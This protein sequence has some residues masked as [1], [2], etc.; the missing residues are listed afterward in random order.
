MHAEVARAHA[1]VTRRAGTRPRFARTRARARSARGRRRAQRRRAHGARSRAC[2]SARR[3]RARRRGPARSEPSR[4]RSAR[5]RRRRS[6]P[7]AMLRAGGWACSIKTANA[8]ASHAS[9]CWPRS[10]R[11]AEQTRNAHAHVEGLRHGVSDLDAKLDVARRERETM[12]NGLL[13]LESDLRS[14]ENDERDAVAGGE[15]HRTRSAE[16]EAELGMLVSQFAQNPATDDECHDVEAALRRQE[17]DTR[18]R[19]FAA[20]ARRACAALGQR[21]P[22]RRG[23][24]RRSCRTR[25]VSA[26]ADGRS[27]QSARDA[28]RIDQ[29]DRGAV[30]SAL[31]RDLREGRDRVHR[32]VRQTLPR[33]RRQDVADQSGES[34]GD[35]HRDRRCSRRA[36]S[37]CRSPRSRAANAR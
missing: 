4:G 9:R 15:R 20:S 29:G 14:A 25:N 5:T 16:I 37:R 10:A 24:T 11:S 35:R 32:D 18:D 13:Q 7:S 1:T 30:P 6:P 31:Q 17:P 33:R 21:Q 28:A 3:D 2:A 26:H 22:Q 23:R 36:R 27:G 19:R 34:F 8:R 12:A